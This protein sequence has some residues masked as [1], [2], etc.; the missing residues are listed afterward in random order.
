VG[1]HEKIFPALCAGQLEP[2]T[3]KMLP[4]PLDMPNAIQG[5]N[6][7][8]FADNT[9]LFISSKSVIDLNQNVLMHN[10]NNWLNDNKLHLCIKKPAIEF[11]HLVKQR[12]I[13]NLMLK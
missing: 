1:A 13:M 11:S 10:L 7:K 3:F 6:L 5:R 4:A 2:P 12:F 9:N 8:L